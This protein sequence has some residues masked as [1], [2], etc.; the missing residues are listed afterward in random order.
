MVGERGLCGISVLGWELRLL[1]EICT[2]GDMGLRGEGDCT[3]RRG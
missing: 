1:G 2:V 3:G